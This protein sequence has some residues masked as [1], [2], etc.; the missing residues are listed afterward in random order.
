MCN[1][2]SGKMPQVKTT[3]EKLPLPH[4][5]PQKKKCSPENCLSRKLTPEICPPPSQRKI[6]GKKNDSRKKLPLR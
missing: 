5:T 3:P 2:V 6:K 4:L 1:K